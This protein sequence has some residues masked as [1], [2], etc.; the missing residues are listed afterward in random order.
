M[1]Y[2]ELVV[3]CEKQGFALVP[4]VKTHQFEVTAQYERGVGTQL[5]T[6]P[7]ITSCSIYEAEKLAYEEAR[8]HFIK[9]KM[10]DAYILEVRVRPL[11]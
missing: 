3:E 1:T 7:I 5:V 2:E 9:N 8:N 4:K 11:N 10:T 6:L